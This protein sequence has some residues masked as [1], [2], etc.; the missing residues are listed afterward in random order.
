MKRPLVQEWSLRSIFR[1]RHRSMHVMRLVRLALLAILFPVLLF[2]QETGVP[3]END[4]GRELAALIVDAA[5]GDRWKRT[6]GTLVFD[7]VLAVGDSEI[8]RYHHRWTPTE[9]RY[10]VWGITRDGRHWRVDFSS[11]S[12][13]ESGAMI[14]G[15]TAVDSFGQRI[16]SSGYGRYI[17]DTYW[18][19]MPVKLLD[20]GVHHA[21]LPDTVIEGQ[22]LNVLAIWF[23]N[24]GLTPGDRYRIFSDPRTHVVTRWRYHLQSGRSAEYHW[25]NVEEIGPLRLPTRR[26][27]VEGGGEIRFEASW[28]GPRE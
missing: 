22:R 12:R 21:R 25:E 11:L 15:E 9:D 4:E 20:S 26:R 8:A 24:V 17:N 23:D 28:E 6:G 19:M 18:L 16:R 10:A 1:A 5:G 2:A 13:R 14:D 3:V 27:A 7:F